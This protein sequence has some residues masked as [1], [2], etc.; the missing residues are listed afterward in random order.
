MA[1]MV[2]RHPELEGPVNAT[3]TRLRDEL[4]RV[5]ERLDGSGR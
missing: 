5:F 4:E 3:L 1:M 2:E